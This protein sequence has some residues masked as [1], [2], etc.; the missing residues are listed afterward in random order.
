[1]KLRFRVLAAL[2]ALLA[3]SLTWVQAGWAS[4]C[5]PGAESAV[6]ASDEASGTDVECPTDMGMSHS[7]GRRSGHEQPDAPAC[8][9][10]PIAAS[11]CAVATPLPARALAVALASTEG[12]VLSS[13]PDA[14]SG[15]LLVSA[16]FR[17]PRA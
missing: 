9:L 14:T 8:P 16:L 7:D 2:L 1:M 10:G 5:A 13:F 3:L 6:V 4:T 17:P 11:G 15:R 12:A